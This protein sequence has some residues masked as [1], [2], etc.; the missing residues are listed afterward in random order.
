[1]LARV[2]NPADEIHG[3]VANCSIGTRIKLGDVYFDR[4]A[5]PTFAHGAIDMVSV[6]RRQKGYDDQERQPTP[7]GPE[8]LKHLP[9]PGYKLAPEFCSRFLSCGDCMA[10]A[11]RRK[12]RRWR[13]GG[14][15]ARLALQFERHQKAEEQPLAKP[16]SESDDT[17]T[18]FFSHE[19]RMAVLAANMKFTTAC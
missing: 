3:I 16:L 15:K 7:Q 6:H 11:A 10:W 18:L 17:R 4:A 1:M 2:L 9:L 8:D 14:T 5:E 13:D 19:I 12:S